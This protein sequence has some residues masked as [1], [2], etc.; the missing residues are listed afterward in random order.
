MGT[1]GA[2]GLI[3]LAL[4]AS[5]KGAVVFV[6]ILYGKAVDALTSDTTPV[7][8]VLPIGLIL[9]YGI[10]RALSLA[11]GELRDAVFAKVGQRAIRRIALEVFKHLHRLSLGFHL[12]RQTGGLSRSIERGMRSIELLLRFSLFNIMPTLIEIA[13][14]F[15]I[16][17]RLLDSQGSA[18]DHDGSGGLYR[19]HHDGH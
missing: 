11:F 4:L 18:G 6:P 1:A 14:V 12:G 19:I 17:W 7:G 10:A 13:L 9:G 15:V 8:L 5:A 3:A 2:G 16:L